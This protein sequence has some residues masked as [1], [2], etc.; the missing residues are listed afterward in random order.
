[1]NEEVAFYL[2]QGISVITGI[3]AVVMMQFKNMKTILFFQI[4]VNLTASLN[5]LLLGGDSGAIASLLAIV[6]STVMFFYNKKGK[7][8]HL[9]VVIGFILCYAACSTYNIIIKSDPMEI[10]PAL[11]AFCFS[12]CL[13]Q[14]KSSIFRVWGALNPTCWLPY[15]LYTQS[16]VMFCVH[17]GILISSLVGMIRIDGFFGLIKRKKSEESDEN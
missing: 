16:Y 17:L 9:A 7:R 12:M 1:M 5:Y 13:V 6:Q 15:D 11:G 2:A 10:F 14:E 8:P 3:L 4:V